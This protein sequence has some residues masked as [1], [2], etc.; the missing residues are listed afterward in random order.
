MLKCDEVAGPSC[1][2]KAAD[3]EP[4]FVL[5]GQDKLAPALVRA[6][7]VLAALHGC[8]DDKVIEARYAAQKMEDWQAQTGRGKWPD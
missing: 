5:R 4:V 8:G 6:W 3:D 1:L 2:T 7:A